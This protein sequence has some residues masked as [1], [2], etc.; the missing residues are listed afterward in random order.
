MNI[1][2]DANILVSAIIFGGKPRIITDLV[3]DQELVGYITE[4]IIREVLETLRSSS[5][6]F[7]GNLTNIS[8]LQAT[9][10]SSR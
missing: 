4:E 6:T 7:S 8:A 1:V 5:I 10:P 9:I 3:I 2:L